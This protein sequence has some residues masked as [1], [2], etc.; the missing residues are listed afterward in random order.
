ME[1]SPVY[2]LR[3]LE[4]EQRSG[5]GRGNYLFF[6]IFAEKLLR[7]VP[8]S[9]TVSLSRPDPGREPVVLFTASVRLCRLSEMTFS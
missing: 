2:P 7:R 8:P 9:L 5:P 4:Q 1:F 3:Q 6:L